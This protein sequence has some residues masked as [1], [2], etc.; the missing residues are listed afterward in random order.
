M[1]AA[2]YIDKKAFHVDLTAWVEARDAL[3]AVDPAALQPEIP[4]SIA[5]ALMAICAKTGSRDNF[6]GYTF[7]DEMVGDAI[8]DC[9]KA[10]K[11]YKVEH[12]KKNPFGYFSKIAWMAM[13][14]RIELEGNQ[15]KL[16]QDLFLDESHEG[17]TRIEGDDTRMDKNELRSFYSFGE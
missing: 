17:F 13:L 5:S 3:R 4:R 1:T 8:Y 16:K 10:V 15:T 7:I 14:R 12:I 2:H 9:V 11:N 6:N